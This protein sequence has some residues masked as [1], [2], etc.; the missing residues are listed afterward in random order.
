MGKPWWRKLA[1]RSASCVCLGSPCA[2]TYAPGHVPSLAHARH[3]L[4]ALVG[5][6]PS[7]PAHSRLG[8]DRLGCF[9]GRLGGL[10]VGVTLLRRFRSETA[11]CKLQLPQSN[12]QSP[13]FSGTVSPRLLRPT[14]SDGNPLSAQK[15]VRGLSRNLA[16][17]S[18][19]LAPLRRGRS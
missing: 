6:A 4:I 9:Y 16:H 12:P 18:P 8:G 19:L 17:L 15:R 10:G 2:S 11:P 14:L 5:A 13:N 3:R 1:W 7:H